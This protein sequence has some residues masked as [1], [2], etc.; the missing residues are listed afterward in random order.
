VAPTARL[1][2]VTPSHQYPL[3]VTLSL[4]RRLALLAWA[5]RADAWILEDDYDSEFRYA[6]HPLAALQGLDTSGRVIY[7]GTFSKTLLPSLR[8]GY[9]I[10]PP[11][12]VD[13]FTSARAVVDRQSPSLE[14]AVLADFIADGH[15][16]RH[17]R[18]MRRLYAER[19]QLLIEAASRE[20]CGVLELRPE[21]AGLHVVGW[22][23]AGTDDRSSSRAAHA[24]GV[25][26]IPLS[27]TYLGPPNASGLL[28]G[29]A[30]YSEAEI[31]AGVREFARAL[32]PIM[33]AQHQERPD[34]T[35]CWAQPSR[36]WYTLTDPA[37]PVPAKSSARSRPQARSRPSLCRPGSPRSRSSPSARLAAAPVAMAG[38]PA[39]S[40]DTGRRRGHGK[41]YQQLHVRAPGRG[42]GHGRGW[43]PALV[44]VPRLRTLVGRA[45]RGALRL[46][47]GQA[48]PPWRAGQGPRAPGEGRPVDRSGR[49][50]SE[51]TRVRHARTEAAGHQAAQAS[52]SHASPSA[53]R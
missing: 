15:F 3:G 12:L 36:R 20:L 18:R 1:A 37:P 24:R 7:I 44:P 25:D 53:R 11:D 42:G 23:P 50:P 43:A 29:Y 16:G 41:G 22:L 13:A 31:R 51:R 38:S 10:V 5:S 6:G 8:L 30:A 9:L 32:V 14:Q 17:V 27:A 34:R 35:R 46:D 48:V 21:S 49:L 47:A 28:L 19:Q 26:A 4:G 39:E 45:V 2:Y 52:T 40:G 33:N